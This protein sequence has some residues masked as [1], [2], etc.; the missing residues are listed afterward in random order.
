MNP[1]TSFSYP[2]VFTFFY[3]PPKQLNPLR[4]EIHLLRTCSRRRTIGATPMPP[5]NI[6]GHIFPEPRRW[7]S[8]WRKLCRN[9]HEG[10]A[11][12]VS[13]VSYARLI[14]IRSLEKYRYSHPKP[15]KLS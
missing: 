5:T 6:P 10:F 11:A 3:L 4:S 9:S 13:Y 7:H 12:P 15:Q 14:N 8:P 2:I 1:G